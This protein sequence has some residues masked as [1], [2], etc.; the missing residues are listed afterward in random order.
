MFN[1]FLVRVAV[2]AL[3]TLGI[4]HLDIPTLIYT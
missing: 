1:F 2:D 4:M 3:V